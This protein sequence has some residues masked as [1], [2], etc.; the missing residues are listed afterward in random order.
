MLNVLGNIYIFKEFT[1][2]LPWKQDRGRSKKGEKEEKKGRKEK[3]EEGK[4]FVP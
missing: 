4:G 2:K 3:K 1:L